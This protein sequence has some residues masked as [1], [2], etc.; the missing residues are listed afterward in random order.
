MFWVAESESGIG[1]LSTVFLISG[2]PDKE[3]NGKTEAL[4]M[5]KNQC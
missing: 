4:G 2:L 1:F 3:K 5:G